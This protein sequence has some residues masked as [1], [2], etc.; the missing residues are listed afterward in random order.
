MAYGVPV[1]VNSNG[2]M[3]EL[4]EHALIKMREDFAPEI[5]TAKMEI[6]FSDSAERARLGDAGIAHLQQHHAPQLIGQAYAT[7]I[8]NF[9]ARNAASSLRMTIDRIA[10]LDMP[11]TGQDLMSAAQCLNLNRR[12]PGKNRVLFNCTDLSSLVSIRQQGSLIESFLRHAPVTWRTDPVHMS[13]SQCH[14]AVADF[15]AIF[16]VKAH[17]AMQLGDDVLDFR[18]GD[19]LVCP[20]NDVQGSPLSAEWTMRLQVLGV[21][22]IHLPVG[23]RDD[24]KEAAGQ[25]EIK[26]C[27][28]TILEESFSKD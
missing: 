5:L 21:R 2:A 23:N 1:I 19:V 6:L 26:T 16:D 22:V 27:W 9:Y 7:A 20:V 8:E 4:P 17:P 12:L 3:A 25:T 10:E 15:D 13:A 18:A 28:R 24:I 11:A 14:L